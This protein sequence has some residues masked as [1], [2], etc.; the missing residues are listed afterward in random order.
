MLQ[1][2]DFV[3]NWNEDGK[4]TLHYTV[5]SQ[6]IEISKFDA[7]ETQ[8]KHVMVYKKWYLF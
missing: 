5:T 3:Y 1:D 2:K 6:S 4:T 8:C 7:N